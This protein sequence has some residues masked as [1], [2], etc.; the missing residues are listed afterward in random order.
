MRIRY[1]ELVGRRVVTA[2]GHHIG[3]VA[4]LAAEPREGKLAVTEL[5]VG[6]SAFLRR[7]GSKQIGL[8]GVRPHRV[9]WSAIARIEEAVVLRLTKDQLDALASEEH[10]TN[11][12]AA[13][14]R[15][16]PGS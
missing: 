13:S 11:A 1:H 12:P 14:T 5:L 7:I 2:D 8:F 16:E 10:R 9:P 6:T 4:D 3:H 15:R